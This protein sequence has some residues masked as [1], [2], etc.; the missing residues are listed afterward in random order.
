[1]Q[2]R[3]EGPQGVADLLLYRQMAGDLGNDML[4]TPTRLAALKTM[5]RLQETYAGQEA[6]VP[7]ASVSWTRDKNGKLVRSAN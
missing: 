4:P 1:M 5:R 6:E 7:K 2:P 3:M